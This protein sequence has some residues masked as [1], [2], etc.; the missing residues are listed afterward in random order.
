M[1]LELPSVKTAADVSAAIGGADNGD[2]RRRRDSRRGGNGKR[3]APHL[4]YGG[5]QTEELEL[6]LQALEEKGRAR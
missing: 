1:Y 3:L 5:L 6:R 4:E 2:G